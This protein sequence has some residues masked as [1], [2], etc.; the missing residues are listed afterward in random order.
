[1]LMIDQVSG[2][3]SCN[4]CG[5]NHR[6]RVRKN[7]KAISKYLDIISV[8]ALSA[9]CDQSGYYCHAKEVNNVFVSEVTLL[10]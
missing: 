9:H 4:A 1:M 3:A 6:A 8:N 2:S 7:S 5:K 10:K